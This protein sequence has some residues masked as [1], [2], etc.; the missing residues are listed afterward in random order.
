MRTCAFCGYPRA[1]GIQAHAWDCEW[2]T[3][4]Q[5]IGH[6]EAFLAVK[7]Q[8]GSSKEPTD[9]AKPYVGVTDHYCH[10]GQYIYPAC[11]ACNPGKASADAGPAEPASAE[12]DSAEPCGAEPERAG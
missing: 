12:A 11:P 10:G 9:N 4:L 5:R 7:D 2:C 1:D 3:L 8:H 6:I